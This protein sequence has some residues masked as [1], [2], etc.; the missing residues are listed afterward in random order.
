MTV[1]H[2]LLGVLESGYRLRALFLHGE[3]KMARKS[4]HKELLRVQGLNIFPK[5][6]NKMG[7]KSKLLFVLVVT[8]NKKWLLGSWIMANGSVSQLLATSTSFLHWHWDQWRRQTYCLCHLHLQNLR[9]GSPG[10]SAEGD[11]LCSLF[12]PRCCVHGWGTSGERHYFSP[13]PLRSRCEDGIKCEKFIKENICVRGNG[14][15]WEGWGGHQTRWRWDPRKGGRGKVGWEHPGYHAVQGSFGKASI[16][17]P[18]LPGKGPPVHILLDADMGGEPH[19]AWVMQVQH[20]C[21]RQVS[22]S[23]HW[24]SLSVLL[25]QGT[26][27][28]LSTA[29]VRLLE[30][31]NKG[32]KVHYQDL[33][34]KDLTRVHQ[35][36]IF[37]L[38]AGTLL[39][40][41]GW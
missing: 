20:R 22:G 32:A 21:Q 30:L 26:S 39:L 12:H 36:L 16:R 19:G 24:G 11:L 33:K 23:L 38:W 34:S 29:A 18:C 3:Q 7:K 17:D 4:P 31:K 14:R 25:P 10:E 5:G 13:G 41:R 40:G 6:H 28:G 15:G 1:D 37:Q 27:G 8:C 9:P 35:Q 2:F